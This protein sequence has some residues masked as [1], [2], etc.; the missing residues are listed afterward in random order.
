MNK[1]FLPLLLI[2]FL[3]SNFSVNAGLFDFL[4]NKKQIQQPQPM[5]KKRRIPKQR[6]PVV[7]CRN[8]GCV[9]TGKRLTNNYFMGRLFDLLYINNKTKVYICEADPITRVC[10]NH[11][12]RAAVNV[13]A[14]VPAVLHIPSLTISNVNFTNNLKSIDVNFLYDSFLNGMKSYCS[15]SHLTVEI[16]ERQQIIMKSPDYVCKFTTDLPAYVSTIYDVNYIDLDYGI[17]GANYHIDIDGSSNAGSL[18]YVLFKF[19]NTTDGINRIVN[20]NCVNGKCSE[21]YNIPDGQYEIIP[22]KK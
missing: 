2:I 4:G 9:E 15:T 18:G 10:K 14:N 12:M 21:K 8:K 11:A 22:M 13:G 17:V 7:L 16:N 3:S 20:E 6:P 19:E 1:K 5:P